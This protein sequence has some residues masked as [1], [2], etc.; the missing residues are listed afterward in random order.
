MADTKITDLIPSLILPDNGVIPIASGTQNYKI[1]ASSLLRPEK[2]LSEFDTAPKKQI[3]RDN[4]N[5]YSKIEV[6][7]Q[8]EANNLLLTKATKEKNDPNGFWS[9]STEISLSWNE[10]TRTLTVNKIGAEFSFF[11]RGDKYTKTV[12]ESIQIPNTTGSY[13]IYYDFEKIL[14]AFYKTEPKNAIAQ[15]SNEWSPDDCAAHS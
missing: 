12:S 7:T 9:A 4:L 1:P 3:A 13:F 8:N 14:K 6:Y 11:I 2:F 10:A 15:G 5:V